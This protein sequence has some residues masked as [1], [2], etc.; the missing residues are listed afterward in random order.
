MVEHMMRAFV[1]PALEGR[2]S[3][4]V[5]AELQRAIDDE[6]DLARKSAGDPRN[7]IEAQDTPRL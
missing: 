1:L 3:A 5:S 2:R 6:L 4:T 7:T